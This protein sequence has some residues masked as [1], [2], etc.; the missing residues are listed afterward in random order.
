M[1]IFERIEMYFRRLEVYINV[2]PTTEMMNTIIL[3]MVEVLSIL[4]VATEE[5]GQGR[6]SEQFIMSM[7]PLT[8]R[9][10]EKYGK[11]LIG[12]TDME[13]AL[14]RL[15]KLTQEEARM[16]IAQNLKATYTVDER[17]RGVAETVVAIDDR[18]AGV[19]DRVAGV[20]D[21]VARV[22]DKVAIVDDSVKVINDK[23]AK[24]I[25]GAQVYS[26]LRFV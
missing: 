16:A 20:D 12:R 13:D 10:S 21:R 7:S 6:M 22:D 8:E 14:K 3:I 2:S 1:D 23:V 9:C 25:Q 5:I 26:R 11:K 19:D 15:D 17:L 24:V 4:G 18:V